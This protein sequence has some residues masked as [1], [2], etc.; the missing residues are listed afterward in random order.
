MS[1]P[2]KESSSP[3][4]I[5]SNLTGLCVSLA[6]SKLNLKSILVD[7][8]DLSLKPPY[9]GRAIALSYGSMQILE[10][11]GAWGAL[12]PYAGKIEQIRVTDEYSPLFL[13]F[14]NESTLGCIIESDHLLEILYQKAL[15]DPNITILD[16]TSYELLENNQDEVIIKLNGETQRTELLIAADGKFSNL[17]KLCAIKELRHNYKQKAIICKVAHQKPHN[18]IAQEIFLP[19]GPFAI[20]PLKNPNESGI[21]WTEKPEI[22]D[23]LLSMDIEKF[24]YF[25]QEKF[26]DYL[27]DISIIRNEDSSINH[28]ASYNLELILAEKYYH[29]QIVLI[30]DAAHSIHPISGQGFNLALRDIAEFARISTKYKN[31]GL[32][33]G[34]YQSL[35]EYQNLRM[36]DNLSMAAI[37]D[38]LNKLFSNDFAPIGLI[39]RLGISAVN[40]IPSLKKFFMEYAMAKR[41]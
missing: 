38:S 9:D 30:G 1:K 33:F 11:L 35:E 18:Q 17:R 10:E 19:H 34:C 14:N 24:S 39:R 37:T 23:L 7:R 36:K 27:G 2:L 12:L 5:G 29:N 28:I 13:H 8:K 21:V 16:K 6:L 41:T 26:T 20:L 40:Q 31:L 4:I 32:S 15:D 25:L 3:I 22:A